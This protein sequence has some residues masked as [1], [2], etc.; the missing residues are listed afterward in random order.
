MSKTYDKA[1]DSGNTTVYFDAGSGVDMARFAIATNGD[2]LDGRADK[3][4]PFNKG[5][6]EAK[7]TELLRMRVEELQREMGQVFVHLTSAL[8]QVGQSTW[9]EFQNRRHIL[10][11]RLDGIYTAVENGV[12]KPLVKLAMT[13]LLKH[14]KEILEM[15]DIRPNNRAA[16]VE[17]N[18]LQQLTLALSSLGQLPQ[19]VDGSALAQLIVKAAGYDPKLILA[20]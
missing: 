15:V 13:I 9:A 19:S 6:V 1:V 3:I 2:V 14:N 5:L 11:G 20:S 12:V 4:I 17:S 8:P 18:N 10:E 7:Q 16:S